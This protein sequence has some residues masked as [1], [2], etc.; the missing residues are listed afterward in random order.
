M[1]RKNRS[2]RAILSTSLAIGLAGC[3]SSNF[4]STEDHK[5]SEIGYID[6]LNLGSSPTEVCLMIEQGREVIYSNSFKLDARDGAEVDGKTVNISAPVDY[7][8]ASISIESPQDF[9]SRAL[10]EL[11][12][13]TG[14]TC[15]SFSL[16]VQSGEIDIF[17]SNSC[18]T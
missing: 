3:L 18:N 2:R 7:E 5:P 16:S 1:R 13:L 6:V 10:S 11:G 14:S 17:H 15:I 4:S 12:G 8:E 9:K